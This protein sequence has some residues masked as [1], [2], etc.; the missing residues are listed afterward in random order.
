ML[1]AQARH[2]PDGEHPHARSLQ[3]G[4]ELHRFVV[5]GEVL[6]FSHDHQGL[7]GLEPAG[8][9][10]RGDGLGRHVEGIN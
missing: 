10:P 6:P 2:H 7:A 1:L 9:V 8:L 5:A 3:F 4:E